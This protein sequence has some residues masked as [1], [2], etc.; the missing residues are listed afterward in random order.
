MT[1]IALL[2]IG[3]AVVVGYLQLLLWID[4]QAR[5]DE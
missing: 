2:V 4:E 5:N 3:P 1:Y